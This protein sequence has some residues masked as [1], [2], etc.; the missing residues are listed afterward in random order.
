M[1]K[2]YRG[3]G[4]RGESCKHYVENNI[5]CNVE[6][7]L[8]MGLLKTNGTTGLL[9]VSGSC[10]RIGEIVWRNVGR[11]DWAGPTVWK[12]EKTMGDAGVGW[13]NGLLLTPV[14]PPGRKIF[15]LTSCNCCLRNTKGEWPREFSNGFPLSPTNWF[16]GFLGN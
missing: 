3:W 1:N 5:S 13:R 16:F 8:P 9:K 11:G 15:C 2:W 12:G 14:R 10:C 6:Q 4:A 7:T